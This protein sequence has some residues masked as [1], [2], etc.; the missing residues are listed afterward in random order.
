MIRNGFM[1]TGTVGV[2]LLASLAETR[3]V[4][5]LATR[6]Q[7][8]TCTKAPHAWD[9]TCVAFVDGERVDWTVEP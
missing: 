7:V 4:S 5:T 1:M 6:G 8:V 3:C 9:E 2:T